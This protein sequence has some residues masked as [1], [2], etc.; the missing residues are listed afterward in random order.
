MDSFKKQKSIL[1]AGTLFGSRLKEI[2][3]L[4]STSYAIQKYNSNLVSTLK[5]EHNVC[6]LS[7]VQ[8]N[9]GIPKSEIDDGIEYNYIRHHG[10]LGRIKVLLCGYICNF[11]IRDR[12]IIADALNIM[13][14]SGLLFSKKAGRNK[15][16][17]TVTDIPEDVLR[18]KNTVYG[19][20]FL[21]NLNMADGFIFL[22]EQTNGKFN[23]RRKPYIIVEGI[24]A[25]NKKI[26]RKKDKICVYAGGLEEKNNIKQMI[27]AFENVAK[28]GECL[29]IFG[30]GN[31]ECRKYVENKSRSSKQ[32][33]YMGTAPNEIVLM[34]ENNA[35]LLIN[36]R[37]NSGEFT[38]YS[39]PSK[40]IEY[41][42]TGTPALINRLDGIPDEY[43]D[44]VLLFS[45]EE[46][47]DYEKSIRMALDLSDEERQELGERARNFIQ[48]RNG[49]SNTLDKIEELFH[50]I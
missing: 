42:N 12:V 35:Q 29:C 10:C 21:K 17:L 28:D 34:F 40:F 36:P 47:S 48:K 15:I 7:P 44:V 37:T 26:A 14:A 3:K 2:I 25:E 11:K 16:I 33:R 1:F 38:K 4:P 45:G 20:R 27:E 8:C 43:Y 6:V 31:P 46:M 49:K 30:D 9:T 39:F 19:K 23:V 22:T 18:L 41:L 32:I 24:V 5:L 50:K 13:L